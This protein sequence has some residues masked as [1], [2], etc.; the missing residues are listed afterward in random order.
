[1]ADGRQIAAVSG[2][3]DGDSDGSSSSELPT[4]EEFNASLDSCAKDKLDG[5]KEFKAGRWETA[6]DKYKAALDHITWANSSVGPML[7]PN[8]V[9]CDEVKPRALQL[10]VSCNLN[11]ALC[12]LQQEDWR[13]ARDFCTNVLLNG[14][15]SQSFRVKALFRRG[16]ALMQLKYLTEARDDL[17]NACRMEP[18]NKE[19]RA[20]LSKC[21]RLE[22]EADGADGALFAK[23]LSGAS[24]KNETEELLEE[25][26]QAGLQ[27]GAEMRTAL[28]KEDR[29][30]RARSRDPATLKGEEEEEDA[31]PG[32]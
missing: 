20:A 7:A 25:A 18:A 4:V 9:S 28:R 15:P 27:I 3:S 26:Q 13:G 19:A 1:M 2:D 23:M 6:R 22:A 12:A 21:T 29:A 17:L 8:L 10:F 5:T 30:A 24:G 31:E 32:V 16:L 14:D 11:L